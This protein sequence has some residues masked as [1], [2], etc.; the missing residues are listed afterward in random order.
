MCLYTAWKITQDLIHEFR[1]YWVTKVNTDHLTWMEIPFF[2][3][4]IHGNHHR[5]AHILLCH[6]NQFTNEN[7]SIDLQDRTRP[8]ST[9]KLSAWKPI[10]D[11][12]HE[13]VRYWMTKMN[14]DHL[15]LVEIPFFIRFIYGNHHRGDIQK[16]GS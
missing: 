3:R 7:P 4:F 5:V 10:P 16:S 6:P 14:V 1:R 15:T 2:I 9:T 13:L 8:P 11:R 12:I